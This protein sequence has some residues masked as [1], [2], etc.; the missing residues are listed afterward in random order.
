ML[1]SSSRN[2]TIL[3]TV[4]AAACSQ[5]E[6]APAPATVAAPVEIVRSAALPDVRV[7]TG[8]VRA[9]S[10]ATLAAKVLGNVTRVLVNEGDRVRAGQ[11]LVEIDDRDVRAKVDQAHAAASGIDGAIASATA[12]ISAADANANFATATYN[13]YAA[14]RERGSVSPHEFEQVVAQQKG[15]VAELERAKRGREQLIAQRR[16]TLAGVAEAETFLSYTQVRSPIDGVV[17]ARMVDPGAQAAPGVPLVAVDSDRDNRVDASVD[18]TLASRVRP[19]DEVS[20][21]GIVAHI[22]HVAPVDPQTRTALVKIAL[23]PNS[24]LQSGTFAHVA[25]PIGTHNGVT[26]PG[27]AVVRNGQLASVFVVNAR[28]TAQMRV[29]TL[30]DERQQRFEVLSGLDAGERVVAAANGIH[31]GVQVRGAL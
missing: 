26:V 2:L 29:I 28:G 8:T 14:L 13:R 5:S 20:V 27:T 11:V 4:V 24:G 22:A 25:F 17:S 15:A 6:Q 23:P 3:A 21:D 16:Q 19:G 7:T 9:A 1:H 10:S 30:G 18:E 31:D 12:A